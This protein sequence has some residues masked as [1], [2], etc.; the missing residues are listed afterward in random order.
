MVHLADSSKMCAEKFLHTRLLVLGGEAASVVPIANRFSSFS[1]TIS[2]KIVT[3]FDG[4]CA[5]A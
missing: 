1:R 5:L 4:E 3:I 2:L